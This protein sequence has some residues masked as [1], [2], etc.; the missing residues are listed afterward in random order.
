MWKI[1]SVEGNKNILMKS[2]VHYLKCLQRLIKKQLIS[3]FNSIVLGIEKVVAVIRAYS[4]VFR[5][6]PE[7]NEENFDLQMFY[8]DKGHLGRTDGFQ[9][10]E[11]EFD[12]TIIIP[13]YNISTYIEEC[14]E[15]VLS[16]KTAYT[17]EL[18]IVDDGSTDDT[19]EKISKYLTNNNIQLIKQQNSGQSAAR[20][21]AISISKGRYLMFVDGD[22]ILL[23]NSINV[24]MKGSEDGSDIV[25]G[26]Y[27]WFTDIIT[28]DMINDSVTKQL[29]KSYS[30]EPKFVLTSTG[31][32]WA[33]I[34]RR[35]L[36]ETLRFPEGYIFEDVITKFILRRKANQVK[37]IG[38]PV[39]GYRRNPNSSSHGK[40]SLKKLDSVWVFPKIAELC[41]QEDVPMDGIF[42]LLSLNHIGLLNFITVKN[43]P[44]NIKTAC[45]KEMKRQLTSI[46]EYRPSKMPSMFR[47]LEKSILYGN[48]EQWERVAEKIL[49]FDMLKKWRECN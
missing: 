7:N 12:L 37:F 18:I 41:F 27:V 42:Y 23:P 39:Y 10:K 13:A 28:Q 48:S 30:K 16:Q 45:F 34:Y 40:N 25:E 29:I 14:I 21:K 32:S 17:Y 46:K 3:F 44:Y 43:Q 5:N 9:F 2:I 6:V 1:H 15:S 33:K 49:G 11:C 22:D 38:V 26:N 8:P 47:L 35:E 19:L 4:C 36:W 31:Y 20:N 24:L